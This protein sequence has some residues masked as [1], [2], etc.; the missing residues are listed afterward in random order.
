[1][2]SERSF[3]APFLIVNPKAYLGGADTLRLAKLTDE[4]ADQF[5]VSVIFTAQHVDLR[6]IAEQTTHLTVTAQHMD[7]I[8][9][10]RGMG[11]IL[12]EGLVEAGAQAVVLNH[13]E[14]P[15]S[16]AVLDATMKRAREIGLMTIVC[17][18]SDKQCRAIACLGPDIMICEPTANI[19]TGQMEAGD[20]IERTT[21]IVKEVDPAIL[22]IQAA[23]V[24]TGAD[25]AQVLTSGADGSGG[26]SGIIKH[27]DWRAILTDMFTAIAT[28]KNGAASC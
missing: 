2:T 18:D 13:A 27:P 16:L 4:L 24:S 8:V 28:H 17:A 12:P 11:H 20:Y 3:T 26:T 23:G 21:H 1:M 22:V 19:G 15:L 5:G 6:M 9:P 25:V 14:H 7:P 10:G